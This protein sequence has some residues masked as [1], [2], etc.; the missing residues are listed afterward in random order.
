M[1]WK[2]NETFEAFIAQ[3]R[4]TDL[5]RRFVPAVG[6]SSVGKGEKMRATIEKFAQEYQEGNILVVTHGGAIGDL[7]R[8]LFGVDAIEEVI[9]PVVGAPHIVID[10]CSVTT[11]AK[12]GDSYQ[13]LKLNDTTFYHSLRVGA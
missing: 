13:L 7:L 1:E 10:E 8:N 3:W 6:D 4:K 2:N 12:D 5:D 11:I 9:D